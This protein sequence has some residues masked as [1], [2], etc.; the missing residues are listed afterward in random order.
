MACGAKE[1][2]GEGKGRKQTPQPYP[3]TAA[4]AG[5]G[6]GEMGA[7]N[8]TGKPGKRRGKRNFQ[9]GGGTQF[10]FFWRRPQANIFE[11]AI[12]LT[13]PAA[14][15][16]VAPKRETEEGKTGLPSPPLRKVLPFP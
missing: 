12:R 6:G 11:T 3:T 13:L 2:E 4:A 10:E 7:G 15:S 14:F 5:E 1:K 8:A 9:G 16:S